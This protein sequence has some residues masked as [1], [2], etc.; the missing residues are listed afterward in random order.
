MN[1]P[2]ERTAEVATG[3]PSRWCGSC[4]IGHR[5]HMSE[6]CLVCFNHSNWRERENKED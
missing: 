1:N 6:E 4:E 3:K 5:D 2:E